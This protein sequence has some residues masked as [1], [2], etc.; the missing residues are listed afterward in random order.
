MKK[1]YV[2]N[3]CNGKGCSIRHLVLPNDIKPK[4]I[5]LEVHGKRNDIQTVLYSPGILLRKVA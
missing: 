5:Y 1:I 3:S 4:S 2:N